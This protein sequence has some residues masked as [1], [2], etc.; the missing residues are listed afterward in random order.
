VDVTVDFSSKGGRMRWQRVGRWISWL[1]VPGLLLVGVSTASSSFPMHLASVA[2]GLVFGV[3]TS[4]ALEWVIHRHLYHRAHAR[5][6]RRIYLVHQ[7]GH[8]A[9]HFPT[10]RYVARGRPRHFASSGVHWIGH[11]AIGSTFMV[12]PAWIVTNNLPF[13]A[14]VLVVLS[15]VGALFIVVHDAMHFPGLHR[16]IERQPWFHWLNRHHYIHHVDTESNVN[17]LLPLGDFLFGTLRTR[18]SERELGRYGAFE[19]AIGKAGAVPDPV[20]RRGRR[21]ECPGPL[22]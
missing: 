4:S 17:F 9:D 11:V 18:L 1:V 6:L 22:A 5:G 14:A 20:H 2:T 7:R 21:D 8:H 13:T 10:W 19:E 3:V 16:R 12:A 15:L